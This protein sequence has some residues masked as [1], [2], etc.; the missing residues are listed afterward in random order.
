M[1]RE[2]SSDPGNVNREDLVALVSLIRDDWND[3]GVLLE[4]FSEVWIC[5]E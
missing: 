2:W 5:I 4:L 3:E 1:L